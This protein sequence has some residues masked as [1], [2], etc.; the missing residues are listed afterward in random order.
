MQVGLTD[1]AW[2]SLWQR[3][4]DILSE[5]GN[6]VRLILASLIVLAFAMPCLLLSEVCRIVLASGQSR[7]RV[8]VVLLEIEIFFWSVFV[9]LP[10]LSGLFHL[11]ER[12]ETE[13]KTVLADVFYAFTGGRSAYQNA[14]AGGICAILPIAVPI[15][16]A[17]A[18][19]T[20]LSGFAE[21]RLFRT[22]GIAIAAVAVAMILL[23]LIL[24]GFGWLYRI[25]RKTGTNAKSVR[26]TRQVGL[27]YLE[28]FLPHLILSV[29]SVL[30]YF[31]A[32]ILPRMLVFYFGLWRTLTAPCPTDDVQPED[33]NK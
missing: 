12:M 27:W 6:R 9:W 32:D 24:G 23:A 8:V 7:I 30:I 18:L 29:L 19:M 22:V 16:G 28:K 2:R 5:N 3:T 4:T 11:A 15:A 26:R 31:V 17:S 25:F 20:A 10:I 21:H 14:L 33:I 13:E 1:G